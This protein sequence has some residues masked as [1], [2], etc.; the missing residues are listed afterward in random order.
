MGRV[1]NGTSN[2]IS[3]D[4]ANVVAIASAFSVSF[5]AL[6]SATNENY[7][8]T[9]TS[10][11]SDSPLFGIQIG[12]TGIDLFWRNDGSTT[13]LAPGTFG[14]MSRNVWHHFCFTDDGAGHWKLYQDGSTLGSGTHALTG[15][16]TRNRVTFGAIRRSSTTN[17]WPGT[18]AQAAS[19]TRLLSA[20]EVLALAKGLAPSRLGPAHYWP[21]WGTD[22]PEPDIGLG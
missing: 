16:F 9:E 13:L 21:L 1:F 14:G 5:W 17:F 4:G 10:S 6:M 2:F 20:S 3:A 7:L 11:G 12:T 18:L 8:Y 22:S 19:W 15:T